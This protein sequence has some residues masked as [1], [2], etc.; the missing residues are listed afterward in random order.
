MHKITRQQESPVTQNGSQ[1]IVHSNM[2]SP[3]SAS[4]IW[5]SNRLNP[6]LPIPKKNY[7]S[8]WKIT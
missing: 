1:C 2:W 5:T 6:F 7:T 4:T 3:P 8:L